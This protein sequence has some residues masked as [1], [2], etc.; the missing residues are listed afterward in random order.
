MIR[1][2]LQNDTLIRALLREPTAYTPIWLMRQAGRYLPEYRALR[3][4]VPDF[5]TLCQTPDLACEVTLQ[6]LNR[7][8]LDGAILFSDILTIPHAMGVGLQFLEGEGPVI[9]NP[10]RSLSSVLALPSPDPEIELVYVMDA[11]R[12]IKKELAHKVPLIGFAGSPWTVACY[13][14]EGAASKTFGHIKTLMYSEPTI[15]H[16]L[17]DKLAQ[18]T[19]TYLN[20]QILAGADIIML[21]DTWGGL[22]STKDYMTF[23][24]AYMQ[25]I[26]TGLI[27]EHEGQ[28]IPRILFTKG[29]GGWLEAM[30]KTDVDALGLDWSTDVSLARARVGTQVAL[31]GNLDPYALMAAPEALTEEIKVILS[32]YGSGSGHVFNLG[33]GID[34]L[35]PY[36]HVDHLVN[37]VHDLSRAYHDKAS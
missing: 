28:K 16:A 8:S 24:L 30:A 9:S 11:I 6:P 1:Q 13:M 27:R 37:T 4:Q 23:S 15:L 29:G 25:R 32:A 34:K 17:L 36:E 33:H 3:S 20:A 10:V 21:F 19:L 5:M 35:T 12:L 26:L 2:V 7:F 31:Q 14:V 18:V 22:L